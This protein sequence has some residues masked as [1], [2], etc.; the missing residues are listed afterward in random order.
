MN[1]TKFR[2]PS[3]NNFSTI[4]NLENA[5]PDHPVKKLFLT[6]CALVRPAFFGMFAR[7]D[8]HR[9]VHKF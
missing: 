1:L 4:E 9:L 7:M 6:S 5:R 8:M 3:V 2:E